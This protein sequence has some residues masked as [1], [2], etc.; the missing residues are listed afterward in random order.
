MSTLAGN[1]R[2]AAKVRPRHFQG[3][4]SAPYFGYMQMRTRGMLSPLTYEALYA[5]T[6]ALPDLPF[7]EIGA[8]TGSATIALAKGYQQSGK[9]S[10]VVTV[11]KCEG[12]SRADHGTRTEN[13]RLLLDNLARFGVAQHVTFLPLDLNDATHESLLEAVGEGPV[14]GFLHDAD[15]RLDRDFSL[16]WHKVVPGGL[17]VVDDYGGR[18]GF[19]PVSERHP[20]GGVKPRLTMA[21]LDILMHSGHFR[22]VLQ[23]GHT[24]FGV[25]PPDGRLPLPLPALRSARSDVLRARSLLFDRGRTRR[26]RPRRSQER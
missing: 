8:A 5:S 17:I 20:D 12:G 16:L 11:E 19:R 1:L 7:V 4:L 22:P 23:I 10:R 9:S 21:Q 25:K 3:L 26:P 14:A 15:G 6:S 24:L 2:M 13:E 18:A